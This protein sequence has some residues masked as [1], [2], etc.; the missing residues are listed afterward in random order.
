MIKISCLAF[1]FLLVFQL[2]AQSVRIAGFVMDSLSG[3]RL[4]GVSVHILSNTRVVMADQ[5]GFFS[6]EVPAGEVSIQ[7]SLSSYQTRLI[8]IVA[9]TDTLLYLGLQPYTLSS[10]VIE[11]SNRSIGGASG[12]YIVS[13]K[14]LAKVPQLGAETDILKALAFLPG[15]ST[16]TEA[17]AGLYIRGGTPDQNL[18]LIDGA[19]VYNPTH[20]F[21][22]YSAFNPD[23]VRQV[24]LYV[25]A[26]PARYGGR[27]SSAMEIYTRDGNRQETKGIA[28]IGL[29]SS[30]FLLEGPIIEGKASY[31]VAARS[32]YLGLVNLFSG[33][34]SATASVDYW[35]Y[36]LHGRVSYSPNE[37]NHFLFSFYNSNDTGTN[38]DRR[39]P[40]TSTDIFTKDR[41][42]V[43]WGNRTALLKWK[44]IISPSLLLESSASTSLFVYRLTGQYEE[45]QPQPKDSVLLTQRTRSAS[46]FSEIRL[47]SHLVWYASTRQTFRW[48]LGLINHRFK[49]WDFS[50]VEQ[51][52]GTS[53]SLAF[54]SITLGA[55]ETFAYAE[56]EWSLS[57][58][59]QVHSGLRYA[60]YQVDDQF[61]PG[62]EPRVGITWT[63]AT[64][65]SLNAGY[66]LT[67]QFMHLLASSGFGVPNDIWIPVTR[68]LPPQ[69]ASIVSG[70]VDYKT[71]ASKP[72]YLT[73]S[74]YYKS[75]RGQVD[76]QQGANWAP[77]DT[78]Q[79]TGNLI[80]GGQGTAYGIEMLLRKTI[81]KVSGSISYTLSWN[82]RQFAE[83]NQG[84]RYPFT[85]DRRHDIFL[86]VS[87][88]LKK[89]WQLSG[90]WI[91]NTG[92]AVTLPIGR[93][94]SLN[95]IGGRL[96]FGDRN[97]GRMP[98]YHRMDMGFTYTK[99]T[100]KP[101]YPVWNISI[102]NVYNRPNPY[103]LLINQSS[104]T[105]NGVTTL[106]Q[107]IEQQSIFNF[108][109]TLS[110]EY[111]F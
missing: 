8:N 20:L 64:Q 27:L 94:P 65:W 33:S 77:G 12:H 99:K 19:P 101:R 42:Q 83:I 38:T 29:I 37:K 92:R 11:D 45:R 28:A 22:F 59:L 49:P 70:G 31:L 88:P 14:E 50:Y 48:G 16:G 40:E 93:M 15:I 107:V 25:G 24:E 104:S 102:Y 10:V 53:E 90:S 60:G 68:E 66:A 6:A 78:N 111:H 3:E 96:I 57:D 35:L 32:S 80:A 55:W 81:G 46:Q 43:N 26:I 106:T 44:R 61:F 67:R 91:Y 89:Q 13:I 95:G 108:L 71:T 2:N 30:R 86:L 34:S 58:A 5:N 75:L 69:Q 74:G 18:I 76:Y 1:S 17:S 62:L 7:L 54:R 84:K 47:Q 9:N 72:L 103:T 63:P 23:A 56:H 97:N 4:A 87:M 109:P 100:H 105:V 85:Y 110:Y 82:Y 36:D 98:V 73:V 41:L 79:W 21:G 51:S 39:F 52:Q